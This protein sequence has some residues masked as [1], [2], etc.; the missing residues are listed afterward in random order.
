MFLSSDENMN[1][2]S[3]ASDIEISP[4]YLISLK[5]KPKDLNISNPNE[6]IIPLYEMNEK[7][8]PE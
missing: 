7:I 2:L 6:G 1:R 3:N 4:N 5:D 8:E